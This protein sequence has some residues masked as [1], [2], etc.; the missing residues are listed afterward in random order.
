MIRA[1]QSD[2]TGIVHG[3]TDGGDL[4]ASLFTAPAEGGGE[5]SSGRAAATSIRQLLSKRYLR[6]ER[7]LQVSSNFKSNDRQ[8][9]AY[10]GG[11]VP[12]N[13]GR[14]ARHWVLALKEALGS[15]LKIH[16]AQ[17]HQDKAGK[18]APHCCHGGAARAPRAA[19]GPPTLAFIKSAFGSPSWIT[20]RLPNG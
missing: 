12:A 19:P 18:G 7:M 3:S 15:A 10:L 8:V 2:R 17:D 6:A 4:A 14:R 11:P 16:R 20:S 1:R 13:D 9:Q 5:G